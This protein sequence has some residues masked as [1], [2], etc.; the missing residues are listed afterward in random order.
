MV[1]VGVQVNRLLGLLRTCG[2]RKCLREVTVSS[3]PPKQDILSIPVRPLSPAKARSGAT[4]F[5][6]PSILSHSDGNNLWRNRLAT[7]HP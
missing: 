2:L 7:K 6:G 4:V 1:S 3:Q 5:G